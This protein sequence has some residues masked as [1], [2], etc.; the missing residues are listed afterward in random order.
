MRCNNCLAYFFKNAKERCNGMN[1]YDHWFSYAYC[2]I[3]P[4]RRSHALGFYVHVCSI[5]VGLHFT[6]MTG[7]WRGAN[8]YFNKYITVDFVMLF[9][10]MFHHSFVQMFVQVYH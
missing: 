10:F 4:E 3:I 8:N 7:L 6:T 5:H 2:L 9:Q 1:L